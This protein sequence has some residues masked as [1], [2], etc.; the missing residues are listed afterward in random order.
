[1]PIYAREP[2]AAQ[3]PPSAESTT[4][5]RAPFRRSREET[6]ILHLQNTIGNQAVQRL[7]RGQASGLDAG[8]TG[9]A[10]PPPGHD[11]RRMPAAPLTVGAI[12]AKLAVNAPGDRDEQEADRVAERVMR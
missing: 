7:L 1:M 3:Q 11:F 9:T 8:S 5:G 12:Q 10:P 6:L 4:P 2:K